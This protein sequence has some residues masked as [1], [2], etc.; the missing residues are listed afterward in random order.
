VKASAPIVVAL[1]AL[2]ALAAPATSAAA[3][4]KAVPPGLS[5]ANQ[6]TE[7]LPGPGGEEP[8]GG[9]GPGTPAAALGRV[10][11]RRLEELGPDGRAAA[12]LAAAGAPGPTAKGRGERRSEAARRGLDPAGP[13]ALRQILGQVTGTSDSG[14]AGLLAPVLIGS[15]MVLAAA[16]AL[17]R[18]RR[19]ASRD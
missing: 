17:G 10:D 8:T 5:A 1:G 18:R 2:V 7:T 11:A 3:T 6:Y 15:A 14:G 13:S 4:P 12:R 9:G 16:Y 19:P